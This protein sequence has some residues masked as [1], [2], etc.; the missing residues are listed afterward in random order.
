MSFKE[1]F[2]SDIDVADFKQK[3]ISLVM[4]SRM[5]RNALDYYLAEL[6]VDAWMSHFDKNVEELETFITSW[7]LNASKWTQE[8][9]ATEPVCED[10]EPVIIS[11]PC[12]EQAQDPQ[13]QREE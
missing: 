1:M 13:T 7:D 6:A 8:A 3:A 5:G 10:D 11:P 4:S 12:N 2:G 9:E